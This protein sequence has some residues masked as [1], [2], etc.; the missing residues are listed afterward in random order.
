MP[1]APGRRTPTSP[2]SSPT[3][4]ARAESSRSPPAT[5]TAWC[6]STRPRLRRNRLSS[7]PMANTRCSA[8][9]RERVFEHFSR[10]HG[11]PHRHR[12]AQLRHRTSLRRAR[13]PGPKGPSRRTDFARDGLLQHHLAARRVRHDPPQLRTR[14]EPAAGAQCH[15]HRT[16][17]RSHGLRALRRIARIAA[18]NS[19]TPNRAPHC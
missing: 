8:I 3:V 10:E 4:F 7:N 2:A 17:F 12:P 1:P 18:P 14:R 5:C 13:R 15:R 9:G 19:P 16:T 6:P 11:T